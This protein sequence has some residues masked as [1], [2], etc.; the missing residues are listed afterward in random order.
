MVDL[1]LGENQRGV[2]LEVPIHTVP[3]AGLGTCDDGAE[4]LVETVEASEGHRIPLEER[5]FWG[6][7]FCALKM[8]HGDVRLAEWDVYS[9]S[10]PSQRQVPGRFELCRSG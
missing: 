6:V 1:D 4:F 8:E 2:Q 3:L 5:C 10:T 7:D 9:Y